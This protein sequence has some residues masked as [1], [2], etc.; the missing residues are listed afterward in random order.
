MLPFFVEIEGVN[1]LTQHRL[2]NIYLLWMNKPAWFWRI[3]AWLAL[4]IEQVL[5]GFAIQETAHIKSLWLCGGVLEGNKVLSSWQ[6][7]RT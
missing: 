3:V 6:F 2:P 7:S 4:V 1:R 5:I